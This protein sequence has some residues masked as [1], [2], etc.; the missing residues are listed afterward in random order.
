MENVQCQC[1]SSHSGSHLHSRSLDRQERSPSQCRP[2]KHVTFCNPEVEPFLG[3]G[4]YPEPQGPFPQAQMGR[5]EEGPLPARRPEIL[6]P[7]EMPASYP[8]IENRMGDLP[9]TSIK[10]MEVWLN[11]QACQLDTPHWWGELATIPDVEDP[12]KLAQKIPASF[13]ILVVRC[14]ALLNQDYTMP[15]APKCLTRSRFLPDD[16][17]YQDVQ[18][19]LLTLAYA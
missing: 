19:Q 11:W 8:D 9:E 17:I 7:R 18:L 14:E 5:G 16:P 15:P 10:N 2:E 4:P 3:E 12:S 1:P 13:L 6:H